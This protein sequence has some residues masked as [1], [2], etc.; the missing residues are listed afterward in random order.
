MI[1]VVA[2]DHFYTQLFK[3]ADLHSVNFA[4]A[5]SNVTVFVNILIFK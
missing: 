5:L 1:V 3:W 2:I 4:Y